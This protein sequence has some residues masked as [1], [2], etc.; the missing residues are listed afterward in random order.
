MVLRNG[1]MDPTHLPNYFQRAILC[2]NL[3]ALPIIAATIL[4]AEILLPSGLPRLA[5]Y[6][7]IATELVATSFTELKSRYQ[8]A[9]Q[10]ISTYGAIN[11]GLPLVRLV[12]LCFLSIFIEE[13]AETETVL[14]TYTVSSLG[15]TLFLSQFQK[16][17]SSSEEGIQPMSISSGL[18]FSFAAFATRVQTEFNKPVLA[19]LGFDLAG[20]FNVAQ[21]ICDLACMPLSALQESLWPRLYSARDPMREMRQDGFYLVVLAALCGCT[22]WLTAPFLPLLLG[23]DFGEATTII[24]NLA[25][26]PLLQSIRSL[27]NFNV[28]HHGFMKLIGWSYATGALTSIASLINLVPTYGI[29]GAIISTYLSEISMAIILMAGLK[30]S[31]ASI[32]KKAR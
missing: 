12:A 2:W 25:F 5:A 1:A 11:A 3:T 29:N 32:Q 22:L 24:R 30:I 13:S 23:K 10:Q 17:S 31:R 16:S 21:R 15:Y 6:S 19:H 26:L 28:I 9:A 27:I 14:W 7:A 20:S 4:I 8:Q 18:P